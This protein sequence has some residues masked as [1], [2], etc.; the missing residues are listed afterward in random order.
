[1][2]LHHR[3]PA[4]VSPYQVDR[5]LS[6]I[7]QSADA[8]DQSESD[9]NQRVDITDDQSIDRVVEPGGQSLFP[10]IGTGRTPGLSKSSRLAVPDRKLALM[11][12]ELGVHRP[13]HAA[14]RNI[15][16]CWSENDRRNVLHLGERIADCLAIRRVDPEYGSRDIHRVI[17]AGI[18]GIRL[19]SVIF[20]LERCDEL[21]NFGTRIFGKIPGADMHIL[22]GVAA[23]FDKFR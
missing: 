6:E 3:D 4:D 16:S 17:G 2:Q 20:G 18:E 13:F 15:E 5:T 19:L 7:D 23:E 14:G 9:R 8:E 1:M 22:D 11:N 10:E 21:A 12:D